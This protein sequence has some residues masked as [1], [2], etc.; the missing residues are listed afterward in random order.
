MA[1]PYISLQ[2]SEAVI[3]TAAAQIYAAYIIAGRVA[4]GSESQWM[5]RSIREAI[6]IAKT[7]DAAV[8]SDNEME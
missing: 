1:K 3:T 4:E 7:T 8:T 5:E 2:P 6:R